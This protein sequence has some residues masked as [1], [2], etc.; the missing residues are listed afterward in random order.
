MVTKANPNVVPLCDILLVLLII[1][2]VISP[3]AQAGVDVRLPD[4]TGLKGKP[5]FL[6][7]E[8]EGLITVN[9]E[10]FTDLVLL[11]KWLT[12]LYRPR[13][14]STIFVQSHKDVRYKYVVK[15]IDVIKS[16]GVDKVCMVPQN[17]E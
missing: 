3:M 13:T 7:I 16:A 14:D 5:V 17:K 6:A 11:E 12:D 8:K 2:M 9:K 10:K 4:R 1:F 15:I